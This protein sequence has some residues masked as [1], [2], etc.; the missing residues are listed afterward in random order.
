MKVIIPKMS[1]PT[2]PVS[3]NAPFYTELMEANLIQKT[4]A[5]PLPQ[6]LSIKLD[7]SSGR[8]IRQRYPG[9]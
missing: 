4:R 1:H 7:K 2:G 9:K 3:D 5:D 6:S 8:I